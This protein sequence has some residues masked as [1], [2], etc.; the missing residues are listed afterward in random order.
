MQL[1]S[2]VPLPGKHAN[3]IEPSGVADN[4]TVRGDAVGNNGRLFV[5]RGVS[6]GDNRQSGNR[7]G[8]SSFSGLVH[9]SVPFTANFDLPARARLLRH[10]K[11]LLIPAIHSQIRHPSPS[12]ASFAVVD[13]VRSPPKAAP[14]EEKKTWFGV[15]D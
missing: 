14:K 15:P 1:F 8:E 9:W 4:R 7:Y 6:L 11:V 13:G 10:A 12:K 5:G 3:S 2:A